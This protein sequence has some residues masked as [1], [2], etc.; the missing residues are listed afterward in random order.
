M[1]SI[2]NFLWVPIEEI[3]KKFEWDGYRWED[4]LLKIKSFQI[5]E[6]LESLSEATKLTMNTVEEKYAYL[7]SLIEGKAETPVPGVTTQTAVWEKVEEVRTSAWEIA[8]AKVKE[9]IVKNQWPIIWGIVWAIWWFFLTKFKKSK[10]EPTTFFWKMFWWMGWI[11]TTLWLTILWAFAWKEVWDKY[12]KQIWDFVSWKEE[13]EKPAEEINTEQKA[14]DVSTVPVANVS[15][16]KEDLKTANWMSTFESWRYNEKLSETY[17][18]IGFTFIKNMSWVKFDKWENDVLGKL[19]SN[20]YSELK[21]IFLDATNIFSNGKKYEDLD[22]L[23]Q[24]RLGINVSI[25]SSKSIFNTLT[26]LFS[27]YTEILYKQRLEPAKLK[28]LLFD[29]NW[30]YTKFASEIFSEDE[31]RQILDSWLKDFKKDFYSNL[32]ISI[33]AKLV[34]VG[35]TSIIAWTAHFVKDSVKWVYNYMLDW[36]P[37]DAK[38]FI[39]NFK[40][41]N[42]LSET[43]LKNLVKNNDFKWESWMKKNFNNFEFFSDLSESEKREFTNFIEFRD[44]LKS[45]IL[46]PK[47][48]FWIEGFEK[49]FDD[50]VNLSKVYWLYLTL[51]GETNFDSLDSFTKSTIYAWIGE[52]LSNGTFSSGS[53]Y[54]QYV[55]ELWKEVMSESISIFTKEDKEFIIMLLERLLRYSD[56]KINQA[57]WAVDGAIIFALRPLLEWLGVPKDYVDEIIRT[58]QVWWILGLFI[59]IKNPVFRVIM[60]WAFIPIMY[61]LIQKWVYDGLDS[62]IQATIDE[63][64]DEYARGWFKLTGSNWEQITIYNHEDLKEAVG[65]PEKLVEVQSEKTYYEIT[66][67]WTKKVDNINNSALTVE[68]SIKDWFVINYNWQKYTIDVWPKYIYSWRIWNF[69]WNEINFSQVIFKDNKFIF[70]NG[71]YSLETSKIF[72]AI[73][74]SNWKTESWT[75]YYILEEG[76][77]VTPNIIH[78]YLWKTWDEIYQNV[79]PKIYWGNL[80]LRKM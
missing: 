2:K 34:S 14:W 63:T 30:N 80:I 28:S 56:W 22:K 75:L 50:W 17:K 8:I 47:Y 12:W 20:K 7:K 57:V 62:H 79:V 16:T 44:K 36:L 31:K 4:V 5:E 23:F 10:E 11:F 42:T 29:S 69:N 37:E 38:N 68:I 32:P 65:N 67:S 15:D 54:A 35:F 45:E 60:V 48:T 61:L 21:S 39:E 70:G 73:N 76:K 77:I 24:D 59:L 53:V 25:Y 41:P 72:Q 9:E 1:E 18:T 51:R 58:I 27:P 19:N 6:G 55:A 26:S 43:I 71:L 64:I 46:K 52:I 78:N 3:Q 33:V 74:D 66:S 49:A 13:S 40:T